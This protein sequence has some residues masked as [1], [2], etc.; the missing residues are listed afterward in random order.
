MVELKPCL[1]C[2]H[3]AATIK[4]TVR[5]G[6]ICWYVECACGL[7]SMPQSVESDAPKAWNALAE[8][9]DTI[10]NLVAILE[11]I[12]DEEQ[13]SYDRSY[14][15]ASDTNN[16]D[17]VGIHFDY[18]PYPVLPKWFDEAKALIARAKGGSQ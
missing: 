17:G 2:N 10:N 16:M 18:T 1:Y 13:A 9:K 12:V 5:A 4:H 15:A 7:A 3:S 11:R 14:R 6:R 8:T